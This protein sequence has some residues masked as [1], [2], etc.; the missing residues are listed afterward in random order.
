M[1]T[2]PWTIKYPSCKQCGTTAPNSHYLL[3]YCVDCRQSPEIRAYMLAAQVKYRDKNRDRFNAAQRRT[4]LERLSR[5]AA[6][7]DGK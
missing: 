5:K 6:E 1:R 3:G 7:G 4:R 2:G